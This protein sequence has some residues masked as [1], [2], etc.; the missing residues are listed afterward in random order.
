MEN[1]IE[2]EKSLEPTLL[3]K[4]TNLFK[5]EEDDKELLEK[6]KEEEKQK[7]NEKIFKEIFFKPNIVINRQKSIIPITIFSKIL[8]CLFVNKEATLVFL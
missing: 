8:N 1:N 7:H 5:K 3:N 2:K 6:E 4:F